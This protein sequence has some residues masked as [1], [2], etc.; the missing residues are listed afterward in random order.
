MA[1]LAKLRKNLLMP[2]NSETYGMGGLANAR[3]A[4]LRD[5]LKHTVCWYT[6]SNHS[7]TLNKS[8]S[9][10]RGHTLSCRRALN[11]RSM[12]NLYSVPAQLNRNIMSML[13]P[14]V[15]HKDY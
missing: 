3:F 6:F 12:T 4:R 5:A 2:N 8:S 7:Q 11:A 14:V 10:Y 15:H 1:V 13:E 9:L